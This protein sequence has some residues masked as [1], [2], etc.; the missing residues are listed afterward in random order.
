MFSL[1]RAS[2]RANTSLHP[3]LLNRALPRTSR[4]NVARNFSS[5]GTDTASDPST[6]DPSTA[7]PGTPPG[8]NAQVPHATHLNPS[9]IDLE[10]SETL[11]GHQRLIPKELTR[12]AF[13]ELKEIKEN[14]GKLWESHECSEVV[15]ELTEVIKLDG[16]SDTATLLGVLPKASPFI[17]YLSFNQFGFDMLKTWSPPSLLLPSAVT[18]INIVISPGG[19]M[20]MFK[21]FLIPSLAGVIPEELHSTTCLHY[22]DADDFRTNLKIENK[23]TCYV[24][25]GYNGRILYRGCGKATDSDINDIKVLSE[26]YVAAYR[27]AGGGGGSGG[28]SG[29][30]NGGA[31][32][33]GGRRERPARNSRKHKKK[34]R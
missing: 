21:R 23:L 34:N 4:G 2:L 1:L 31:S 24:F 15:P 27:A 18:P 30:G 13:W 12:G 22:G 6:A 11:L 17:I 7:H 14:K 26:K 5:N 10:V 8:G 32:G 28:G 9:S 25:A 29:G 16:S 20:K 33:E 3:S 19:L